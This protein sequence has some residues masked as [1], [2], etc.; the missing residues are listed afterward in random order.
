MALHR[1]Q[2]LQRLEGA[3]Q[4]SRPYPR[5]FTA[6]VEGEP[7]A[8]DEIDVGVPTLQK[9]R[10]VSRRTAAKRMRRGI[11]DNVGLR[12]DDAA[13]DTLARAIVDQYFSDQVACQ[14]RCI[15]R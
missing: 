10:V 8:V 14:R 6:D 2:S 7:T 1:S 3:K 15:L 11:A 13:G 9:Q 5:R 4:D 12:L